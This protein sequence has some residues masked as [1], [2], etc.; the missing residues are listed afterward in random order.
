[1][2]YTAKQEAVQTQAAIWCNKCTKC[3]K[4]ERPFHVSRDSLQSRYWIVWGCVRLVYCDVLGKS[5]SVRWLRTPCSPYMDWCTVRIIG[6][7]FCGPGWS[8]TIATGHCKVMDKKDSAV[9]CRAL[10]RSN[11]RI[12]AEVTVRISY[13]LW[14]IVG[15]N[16]ALYANRWELVRIGLYN[17]LWRRLVHHDVVLDVTMMYEGAADDSLMAVGC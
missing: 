10:L 1:M 7:C 16:C 5:G 8:I 17:V 11:D 4:T 14:R 3:N 12:A 13:D 6:S 9:D 2:E 15:Q